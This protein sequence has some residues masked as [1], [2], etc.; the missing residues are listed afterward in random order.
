MVI[1]GVLFGDSHV[2]TLAWTLLGFTFGINLAVLI[3]RDVMR[4]KKGWL[5]LIAVSVLIA[6]LFFSAIGIDNLFHLG[7]KE[8]VFGW[9]QSVGILPW[10]QGAKQWIV[11]LFK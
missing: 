7:G 2:K 1:G 4:G 11:G 3:L 5:R 10:L 9:L 6:L 8:K